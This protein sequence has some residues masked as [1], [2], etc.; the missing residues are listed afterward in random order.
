MR[1]D[2]V[3]TVWDEELD[4]DFHN[5]VVTTARTVL[6]EEQRK[7][8]DPQPKT[9]VDRRHNAP[10]ESV[11]MFGTIEF[12]ERV[13]LGEIIDW[14][15][16]ALVETSPVLKGDYAASHMVLVNGQEASENEWR[17]IGPGD[18]IQFVNIQPYARRIE[19]GARFVGWNSRVDRTA[20]KHV[21]GHSLQ[22]P[23]GVYRVVYAQAKRKFGRQVF[24]DYK[25]VS[26]AGGKVI[27][28][29]KIKRYRYPAIQILQSRPI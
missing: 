19:G 17:A 11:R 28:D 1:T 9:I 25:F 29:S 6:R 20:R 4:P 3:D 21:G 23:N 22:A 2:R 18:R 16:R 5:Y 10:I 13:E 26:L 27:A 8:F 7:G 15:Y 14:I 12:V 24:I